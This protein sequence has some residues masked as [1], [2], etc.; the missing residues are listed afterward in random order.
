M[1]YGASWRVPDPA[2]HF[3]TP[4]STH[5]RLNGWFRGI[6]ILRNE[7]DRRYSTIKDVLPPLEPSPL[8]RHVAEQGTPHRVVD[9]LRAVDGAEVIS[10]R[11]VNSEHE[12][13]VKD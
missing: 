2:F 4:R 7:W 8:A 6:R 9:V 3:E 11:A 1:P 10:H 12:H 13:A 5:R